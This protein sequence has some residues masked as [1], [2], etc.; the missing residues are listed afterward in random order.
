MAQLS[1]PLCD[2]KDADEY[3][4][5]QHVELLHPENGQSPFIAEDEITRPY[6]SSLKTIEEGNKVEEG[7]KDNESPPNEVPSTYDYVECS[8]CSEFIVSAE[9]ATHKDLHVAENI[10]TMEWAQVRGEHYSSNHELSTG[11]CNDGNALQDIADSFSTDIPRSLRNF[12]QIKGR[13]TGEKRRRTSLKDLL[14]GSPPKRSPLKSISPRKTRRLGHAELGP[15]AHE[16]QMP[17]WLQK[18]LERGAEVSISNTI[19]HDGKLV[20]VT[21]IVNETP[22][23]I[24][25]LESLSDMDPR[26]ERAYYCSAATR[27]VAKMAKEGG[28]CGYRNIQMVI[29]YIRDAQAQGHQH[30]SDQKL[31]SILQLQDMIENAWDMGF[32]AVGRIETGGIRLTRKYIGTPEAQAL[33]Q[34]LDIACEA[35][36]FGSNGHVAAYE[37]LLYAVAEYFGGYK[38]DDGDQKVVPT[39][40]PPLYFQHQGHSMTIVGLEV[41]KRGVMT[42]IVFDPMFNP[43]KPVKKLIAGGSFK[44][45]KDP[46]LL[47]RAYR[48]DKV[49]LKRYKEFEI[50]RLCE[51]LP[52]SVKEV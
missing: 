27:H 1:C 44:G 5:V 4:L 11:P 7:A 21:A 2:F 12:D 8:I 47:M 9:S 35:D 19:G 52:G 46:Q 29:S 32:N 34:S 42:L 23:L 25:V 20:K 26:I 39:D 38:G 51:P 22:N 49:Y 45:I 24:P 41:D 48:R 13:K 17:A 6:S 37:N 30:F 43:S 14:L 10:Q 16:T 3:F 33:F 31:P 28:F 36:A 15:H 18:L 40:L 50:L